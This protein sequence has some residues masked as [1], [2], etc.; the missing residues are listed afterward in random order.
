MPVAKGN[1]KPRPGTSCDPSGEW[2]NENNPR[3]FVDDAWFAVETV[4]GKRYSRQGDGAP[5]PERD[6]AL[7]PAAPFCQRL[8]TQLNPDCCLHPR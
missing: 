7:P 8:E 4:G 2:Q 6:G 3:C 1:L 5:P